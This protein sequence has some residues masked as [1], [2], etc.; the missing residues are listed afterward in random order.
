MYPERMNHADII[1]RWPSLGDFADDLG[2][3]YDAAKA[4]RRRNSIPGEYW[5]D[6]VAKAAGRSLD[7]VSYEVLA[8][9][10]AL[11]RRVKRPAGL[12]ASQAGAGHHS[13]AVAE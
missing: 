3:S 4:M 6:V 10:A 5:E 12:D 11:A 7:N 1:N 13:C 2:V 9:A 8:A